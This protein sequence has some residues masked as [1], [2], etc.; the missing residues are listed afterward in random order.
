M[1]EVDSL[2]AALRDPVNPITFGKKFRAAQGMML[3]TSVAEATRF[4]F[5][6]RSMP[7][8]TTRQA[9]LAID[10]ALERLVAALCGFDLAAP[11][12]LLDEQMFRDLDERDK[13][14]E[15]SGSKRRTWVREHPN[16]APE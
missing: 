14:L 6:L 12:A 11:P 5:T 3:V 4:V 13:L 16:G 1:K 9:A 15:V 7:P 2:T 10:A 8:D